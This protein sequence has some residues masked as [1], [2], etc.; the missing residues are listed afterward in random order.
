LALVVAL[1]FILNGEVA[2]VAAEDVA[3]DTSNETAEATSSVEENS[4]SETAVADSEVT[5]ES[6]V[7]TTENSQPVEDLATP[8]DSVETEVI[9]S[10]AESEVTPPETESSE[11]SGN[12]SVEIIQTEIPGEGEV[13]EVIIDGEKIT[14]SVV[15]TIID[16]EVTLEIQDE[17]VEEEVLPEEKKKP[18]IPQF[19]TMPLSEDKYAEV[20]DRVREADATTE[21]VID[22]MAQQIQERNHLFALSS[23]QTT[24][25][26]YGVDPTVTHQGISDAKVLYSEA[27]EGVTVAVLDTGVNLMHPDLQQAA[28]LNTG[29]I[30]DN[31][32]DDDGN[33]FI[34]DSGGWNFI[35]NNKNFSDVFGHGTH[36]AGLIAAADNEIG[37]IGAA[38]KSKIL[39]LKVCDDTGVCPTDRIIQ[40]LDYVAQQKVEVV[41]LA[42]GSP[43]Y[44]Y[45]LENKI[46]QL[47]ASGVTIGAS[48]GNAGG[49]SLYYP[50]A[51]PRV[52]AVGAIDSSGEV[53]SFSNT[54]KELDFVAPGVNI[55]S[56]SGVGGY[57]QASGTSESAAIVAGV[58]ALARSHFPEMTSTA[59]IA[60]MQFSARDLA[61]AGYDKKSGYGLIDLLQLS[62]VIESG[63]LPPVEEPLPPEEILEDLPIEETLPATVQG[64]GNAFRTQRGVTTIASGSTTKIL[65]EGTDYTACIG[66]CYIRITGT[67]LSGSG[68]TSSGGTQN[69]RD[70]SVY[71]S[72]QNYS[73]G[74][75]ITF[76]RYGT[77]NNTRV[78][79]E[80]VQ[81]IGAAGGNNEL[82][83][84]ATTSCTFGNN[85]AT[86]NGGSVAPTDDVDVA[87]FITGQAGNAANSTTPQNCMATAAWDAT[88]HRPVF[89]RSSTN[90]SCYVS[91]AVVEFVGSN[92]NVE[93]IEHS[94]ASTNPETE[95][96]THDV[97]SLSKAFFQYQHRATSNTN[98][99]YITEQ[100][101]Q[102]YLSATNQ[103]TFDLQT[104][105]APASLRG[106]VWVISNAGIGANGMTVQHL[107][108]ANRTSAGVSEG[109]AN[110]EDE[111]S[112][113]INPVAATDETSIMG[114][115]SASAG[116]TTQLPSGSIAVTLYDVDTVKLYH[117]EDTYTQQYSFQ[118]VQWPQTYTPPV[119][120]YNSFRVQR[121]TTTIAS[122]ATTKILYEGTDYE[123]CEGSCYLRIVNTR[124]SGSGK[125]SGGGT[126]N[127]YDWTTYISAQNYTSGGSVTLRRYGTT[128]DTHVSW[129]IVEYRGNAG[130]NNELQVLAATS[131]TFG[132]SSG[133]CTGGSVTP[134]DD[135]DVVV[136]ITGQASSSANVT[137]VQNCMVTSAWD[138]ANN[139]PVFTRMAGSNPCYTSYAVVEFTGSNWNVER[140]EHAYTGITL[141]TQALT[142][143]VG[144]LSKAFF[145]AQHRVTSNTY[146]NYVGEISGRVLLS[147]TNQLSFDIQLSDNPSA[148]RGVVWVISN[149]STGANGISV[150]HLAPANRTSAGVSEG[151]AN[152]E[153][154]WSVDINPL[155]AT[156]EASIMGET[157][158]SDGYG[159]FFPSGSIS[160][161]LYDEDT[162][163]FYHSEDTYTQQYGF[164]V[165]QWPQTSILSSG[166][167]SID[168]VDAAG[169]P[170]ANPSVTLNQA[171]YSFDDTIS[172]GILG[173][174]TQKI[175][176]ANGSNL[177]WTVSIAATDGPFALWSDGASNSFD[178]NDSSGGG[179]LTLD[180]SVATVV[181]ADGGSTS[182]V[183]LG[184]N[185]AFLQGS[186]DNITLYFGYLTAL[187][188]MYD[189][190]GVV[191]SQ[192][193]PAQKQSGSYGLNLIL[194]AI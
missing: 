31:K 151:A 98:T 100:G 20:L 102:V 164:Q 124:L 42:L 108:P 140:V 179:Q 159:T 88:N 54:G 157:A 41:V 142:H 15:A 163:K 162:V 187:N 148:L 67:R 81:Y 141:E 89:T 97:G 146:T 132:S 14:E 71:V 190:T 114:E 185:N 173:A 143:D 49:S 131:C 74:G 38:P 82:R 184:S 61:E 122:G 134:Y 32:K 4:T 19:I 126:Q 120:N 136:F 99:N 186:V 128:S 109:A 91:Y 144:S 117:S 92:W 87:V 129:E 1:V 3:S 30:P 180:P 107:T 11:P 161:H 59:L 5:E 106:V 90:N 64:L 137:D 34:D 189:L 165:L 57:T 152:E 47:A 193:I 77:T 46:N 28:W 6:S 149:S 8:L 95:T 145:Q 166:T 39:P 43:Y 55:L 169:N 9:T 25:W 26:W 27:G 135:N 125:T 18:E 24:D 147:A 110:E 60:A 48:S 65:Y 7:E 170:V 36:V 101:G 139:R 153:D 23:S 194:T 191:L 16:G 177:V 75:S 86:C 183:T 85:S 111:W 84:L 80:I 167:L 21:I 158:A 156:Y 51:Y 181:R 72:A 22:E 69:I 168:I 104:A 79:W 115:T 56:T 130:G 96:L 182:G 58:F 112:V 116:G 178:F 119:Q 93:R 12:Q 78:N 133:S 127:T 66:A 103:I 33:G 62:T 29:E 68:K 44:S 73:S 13:A 53:A 175:R 118:V 155:A 123:A 52:V 150:Q 70:W 2:T 138:A 171:S 40:A 83:V 63:E 176:L 76:R 10:E 105:R 172:T 113:D 192:F 154:E 50:A 121:G 17:V 188:E 37:V 35:D 45:I 160:L 94:Y 174:S